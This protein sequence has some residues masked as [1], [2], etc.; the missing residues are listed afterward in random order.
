MIADLRGHV[1][2]VTGAASGIGRAV[3]EVF[4]EQG[5]VVWATDRDRDG[6]DSLV[7]EHGR[8]DILVCSAGVVVAEDGIRVNAVCDHA[9]P[10]PP[11]RDRRRQ[12]RR[13]SRLARRRRDHGAMP[14]RRRRDD[15]LVNAPI[16][17]LDR[18]STP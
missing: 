8:L 6:L 12:G 10:P 14:A 2:L 17:G 9:A 1:A 18:R 15:H 16:A 7:A 13:L 5:A 4:I 3:V 11:A